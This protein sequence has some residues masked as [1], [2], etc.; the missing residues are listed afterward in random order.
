MLTN[1]LN[2]PRSI[3]AAVT[4]DPYTRGKSDI[5]VTSL[6]APPYQRKLMREVEPVEDVA[7]RIWSLL[8]QSV[9]TVLER[10]YPEGTTDAVVEERLYLEHEGWV[11]SGQLDVLEANV[12]SDFKVTSVWSRDGKI[13][14]ERQLNLLAQ[15]CW[16]H[17]RK[18]GDTRYG[19]KKIQI[20][21]IYRDWVKSKAVIDKSYPQS[22]VDVIDVPLW[23]EQERVDYLI[24]R[25]AAHQSKEPGPCTD[26]ERWKTETVYALM[27][28]NRKTAVKLYTNKLEAEDAMEAGSGDYV[29]ERPGEYRRCAGY[30]SVSHACPKWKE[31]TPF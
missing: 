7:D 9:H 3:V 25:V 26:E 22:Q 13:E 31:E 8:G 1:R 15:L 10:A 23:S 19:V 18:T 12:L 6:I 27:K 4:N 11:I 21:A 5:S 29:I 2:L 14:W 24:E 28:K 17:C 30:C 16:N 20:I